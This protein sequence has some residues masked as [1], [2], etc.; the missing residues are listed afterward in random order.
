MN[1]SPGQAPGLSYSGC[2]AG[3][4]GCTVI[5]AEQVREA[6]GWVS[7]RISNS[8]NR[9]KMM[10]AMTT[11]TLPHSRPTK[12]IFREGSCMGGRDH[13]RRET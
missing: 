2:E 9:L 5:F 10:S 6:Q 12:R 13:V 3:V 7:T 1:V 8:R 4:T 11:R